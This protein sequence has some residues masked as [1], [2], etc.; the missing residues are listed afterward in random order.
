MPI[1]TSCHGCRKLLRVADEHAGKTARCPGCGTIYTVPGKSVG[2]AAAPGYAYASAWVAAEERWTLKTPDGALYG[3]ASRADL[4]RWLAEGR[5]TPDSHLQPQGAFQWLPAAQ[6]YPQLGRVTTQNPFADQFALPPP[7]GSASAGA[8]PWPGAGG[9]PR[10]REPHRGGTI[11]T[12]A[13]LGAF[14]CGILTIAALIMAIVDLNKMSTGQMDPSGRGMTIAGLVI[15]IL[16][17][18]VFFGFMF[19]SAMTNF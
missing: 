10:W 11:L 6:V 18:L 16:A 4:D 2:Q 19:A 8:Y 1:E 14:V 9:Q 5:I 13:I 7:Y 12:M 17:L 15:A 3:P